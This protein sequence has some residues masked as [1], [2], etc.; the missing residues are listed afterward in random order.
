MN[1]DGDAR[2][3]LKNDDV[4]IFPTSCGV[5]IFPTNCGGRTSLTNCG[6]RTSPKNDGDAKNFPMSDGGEKNSSQPSLQ[7]L[8]HRLAVR[9]RQHFCFLPC[10]CP[11]LISHR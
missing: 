6:G 11:L 9:L 10:L 2:N 5:K 8:W 4:R 3:S 7:E 1:D